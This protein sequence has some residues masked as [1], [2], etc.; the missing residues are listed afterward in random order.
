VLHDKAELIA[1]VLRAENLTPERATM[2]GDR[3][4]DVRGA[5]ASGARAIGALWGYGSRAELASAGAHALAE[6][7]SELAEALSETRRKPR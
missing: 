7:P 4:Q 5:R 1:H 6:R 2:I 3:A